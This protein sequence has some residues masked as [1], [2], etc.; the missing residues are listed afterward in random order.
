[1]DLER[2]K[3]ALGLILHASE[4]IGGS[5]TH[6]TSS[7]SPPLPLSSPLGF[8]ASVPCSHPYSSFPQPLLSLIPSFSL[9]WISSYS[10][11]AE[12]HW[13][14]SSLW[15]PAFASSHLHSLLLFQLLLFI[16]PSSSP[17][18]SRYFTPCCPPGPLLLAWDPALP[19]ASHPH[20]GFLSPLVCSC[21]FYSFS[22]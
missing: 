6:Y 3:G 17:P 1:M 2:Q 12:A 9:D 4:H 8:C 16:C 13:L 14:L 19:H 15:P 7:L 21:R 22:L 5:W 20:S 11:T 10:L 18:A